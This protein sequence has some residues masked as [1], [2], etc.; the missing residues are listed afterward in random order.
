[1]VAF[2]LCNFVLF[3]SCF[4]APEEMSGRGSETADPASGDVVA[5]LD[6]GEKIMLALGHFG[7][8]LGSTLP[9]DKMGR[10]QYSQFSTLGTPLNPTTPEQSFCFRHCD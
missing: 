10:L 9:G 5:I 6:A 1:M 3:T 4:D 8:I 2:G 7:E